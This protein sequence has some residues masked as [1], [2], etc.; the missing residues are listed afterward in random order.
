MKVSHID[1]AP[2]SY[3]VPGAEAATTAAPPTRNAIDDAAEAEAFDHAADLE[4]A[5]DGW[6]LPDPA[7]LPDGT[8]TPLAR[9]RG[10]QQ[11]LLASRSPIT[12]DT[13]ATGEANMLPPEEGDS[14][15]PLVAYIDICSAHDTPPSAGLHTSTVLPEARGTAHRRGNS[16]CNPIAGQHP[17]GGPCNDADLHYSATMSNPPMAPSH[18]PNLRGLLHPSHNNQ[19]HVTGA[20]TPL[21][22]KENKQRRGAR[23]W[24]QHLSSSYWTTPTGHPTL[25]PLLKYL[26][27]VYVDDFI[28]LTIP[29]TRAQL[30][31]V[32]NAVMC[33]VHDVFPPHEDEESD[34]I[35]FKNLVQGGGA[36]DEIKEILGFMF[37]GTDKT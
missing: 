20:T 30:D 9:T 29:T 18:P 28:G 2:R 6:V 26:I 24:E 22:R 31:H 4:D 10:Q 36:W 13:I 8:T 16:R 17:Q 11:R 1:I 32:A 15:N 7:M 23:Q 33:A 21:L 37:N 35:S 27:D 12:Q 3:P 5:G 34:P 19:A 25:P 14:E